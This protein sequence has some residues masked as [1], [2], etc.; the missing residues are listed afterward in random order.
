MKVRI[1]SILYIFSLMTFTLTSNASEDEND[2]DTLGL[3]RLGIRD[4]IVLVRE[5]NERIKSYELEW[6]IS[7]EAINRELSV[8]EPEFLGSYRHES[9]LTR[10]TLEEALSRQYL[11]EYRMRNN[12]Y[13][14]AIEGLD[15][16]GTR[17]RLGYTLTDLSTNIS[18]QAGIDN[19]YQTFLGLNVTQPL[20]KNR[21]VEANTANVRIAEEDADIAFQTYRQQM[22]LVVA[23]AAA[24][25]WDLYSAQE[26][27]MARKES[28]HIARRLLKDN[29]E[30]VK[31]G[32]MA[33]SEVMEAEAGLAQRKSLESAAE[34]DLVSAM[35]NARTFFSS[36][37]EER[38][39]K[40]LAT[41]KL[42][43]EKI[44]PDFQESINKTFGLRPEYLSSLIKIKR[45]DIQLA[46][47]KNQLW[48]QLDLKASY[49]INGLDMQSVRESFVDAGSYD[50]PTWGVGL[51]L[52]V[53]IGGRKKS[54][55]ELAMAK[56]RKE[57]ALLELKAVE[58]AV[59]NAVHTAIRNIYSMREQVQYYAN[60]LD[61][62]KKL[63][64]VEL[65]RLKAGKSNSRL[66][67]EREENYNKAKDEALESLIKYKRSI[68]GLETA[69]G[70]LLLN[71]G[72]EVME[73]EK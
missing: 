19:E 3:F 40:I 60:V 23:N 22:I 1:I 33:E 47:A 5:K 26:K 71:H 27:V 20:L 45:G 13:E 52:R 61:L 14:A 50:Y 39:V 48:P 64:N 49:G 51:E 67:L 15:P 11:P 57:Q 18:K 21:G 42:E 73:V 12:N 36:T 72:I 8:F 2:A 37:T 58:V 56:K 16:M 30:R 6:E 59:T 63:L 70:S 25:Y 53:P 46:F 31:A 55:S 28:V 24:V 69:E 38:D 10:N 9:S 41:D 4:F 29:R 44:E 43:I 35:N 65:E 32:K 34:Q 7:K 17:L 62:N 66:V 54:R 68:V